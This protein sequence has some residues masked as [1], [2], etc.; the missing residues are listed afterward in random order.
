MQLFLGSCHV[1][2]IFA[3]YYLGSLKF[4]KTV[5][6]TTICTFLRILELSAYYSAASG[7]YSD[8]CDILPMA[9]FLNHWFEPFMIVAI[10]EFENRSGN[11]R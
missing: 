7:Y 3:Y 9:N 2:N 4:P 6:G 1:T 10:I 5:L 8:P 11:M